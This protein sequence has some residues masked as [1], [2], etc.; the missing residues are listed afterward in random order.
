[1]VVGD[2]RRRAG[3]ARWWWSEKAIVRAV[4]NIKSHVMECADGFC[5]AWL[6]AL[7]CLQRPRPSRSPLVQSLPRATAGSAVRRTPGGTLVPSRLANCFLNAVRATP[8]KRKE[9]LS[10]DATCLQL[11]KSSCI[12]VLEPSAQ[13]LLPVARVEDEGNATPGVSR[14]GSGT[15]RT[16]HNSVLLRSTSADV[17][18]VWHVT[19]SSDDGDDGGVTGPPTRKARAAPSQD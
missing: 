5:I 7:L 16:K 11:G 14:P 9:D 10:T 13:S 4:S 2:T 12:T 3:G 19:S 17:S 15:S 18:L 8:A 6:P 1:M